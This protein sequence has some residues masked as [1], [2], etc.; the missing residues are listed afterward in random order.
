MKNTIDYP[1]LQREFHVFVESSYYNL[2]RFKSEDNASSFNVLLLKVLPRVKRYIGKN[3]YAAMANGKINVGIY[4][5]DDFVDQLFIEAYEHFDQVGDKEEL[6]PWLYKKAD[7]LLDDAMV[8]EE[9]D[10][11]FFENIDTYTK[12]EWDAMEEKYSIDGGGDLVMLEEFDDISYQKKDFILNHVFVDDDE[13]AFVGHLDN[14]LKAKDIEKHTA[15]VLYQLPSTMRKVFELFN[16]HQ[17]DLKEIGKI[18]NLTVQEV[19][20]LLATAQKG[21]LSSFLSRYKL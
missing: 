20:T 2:A 9:F 14:E 19:E 6:H 16:E 4:K 8:E 1:K 11:F 3:L 18:Q 12:P 17:F 7:E 10:S 5:A 13:K 21:L 15:M